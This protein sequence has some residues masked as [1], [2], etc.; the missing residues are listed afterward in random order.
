MYYPRSSLR[1]CCVYVSGYSGEVDALNNIWYTIC[2]I[3]A[4]YAAYR[5]GKCSVQAEKGMP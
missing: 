1:G 2:V 4:L 5:A 3:S